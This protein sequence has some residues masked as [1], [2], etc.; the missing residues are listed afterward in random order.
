MN[1]RASVSVSCFGRWSPTFE[2]DSGAGAEVIRVDF[3]GVE[4]RNPHIG[5]H[6]DGYYD[7]GVMVN[8]MFTRLGSNSPCAIAF[9]NL[10]PTGALGD[11]PGAN[12]SG[13]TPCRLRE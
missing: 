4:F 6:C 13:F 2:V 1:W 7:G 3:S 9:A 11:S 12:A 8:A 10:W 5:E